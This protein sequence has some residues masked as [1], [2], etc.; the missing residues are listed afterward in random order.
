MAII[1]CPECE[2]MVSDKADACPHCGYPVGSLG[3]ATSST[4]EPTIEAGAN[5]RDLYNQAAEAGDN[6]DLSRAILLYEEC[7]KL[8]PNDQDA[9][10]NLACALASSGDMERAKDCV[11]ILM[12]EYPEVLE[13]LLIEEKLKPLHTFARGLGD[14]PPEKGPVR[15]IA[16]ELEQ[17]RERIEEHKEALRYSTQSRHLPKAPASPTF[18]ASDLPPTKEQ[19]EIAA[20]ARNVSTVPEGRQA[21]RTIAGLCEKGGAMPELARR[22]IATAE[23]S[24]DSEVLT[25]CEEIG[26]NAG[27]PPAPKTIIHC[28]NCRQIIDDVNTKCGFC[29]HQNTPDE[30]RIVKR[31]LGDRGQDNS[32]ISSVEPTHPW[33]RWCAKTTDT[34]VF[35][36][37]TSIVTYI[38][39]LDVSP[40]FADKFEI[41]TGML[42]L[43]LLS[44]PFFLLW[45]PVE[46]MLLSSTGTTPAKWLW[47]ISIKTAEGQ[48]I[49]FGTGF[50][51]GFSMWYY[52][53]GLSIPFVAFFTQCFAYS[54]LTETGATKWDHD[55]QL[56]VS[57]KQWGVGRAL[58]CGL[59]FLLVLMVWAIHS[60]IVLEILSVI[61][62]EILSVI[63]QESRG[64]V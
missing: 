62:Q 16:G 30:K 39:L 38:I 28:A 18:S 2:G 47:G 63:M 46:A 22:C 40:A 11:R 34:V 50:R 21:L 41:L 17:A 64:S 56:V 29:G 55:L 33:R 35:S 49:S 7:L 45:I 32:G 10:F 52:G 36:T 6:N 20:I 42:L 25:L 48:N 9:R 31:V 43:F 15:S 58:L 3:Q 19:S 26:G 57:H 59:T 1:E 37:V 23:S 51:R 53:L 12:Q 24:S 4:K 27:A 44:D 5:P 61:M 54:R 13:D 60:S 14:V 8:T